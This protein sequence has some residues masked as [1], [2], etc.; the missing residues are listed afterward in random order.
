ME[1]WTTFAEAPR[2]PEVGK[3]STTSFDVER[4]RQAFPI[5]AETVYGKPLVYL[6]SAALEGKG[7]RVSTEGEE[8][9]R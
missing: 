9:D 7:E 8:P 4:L 2:A 6:D 5:L 1:L 3:G